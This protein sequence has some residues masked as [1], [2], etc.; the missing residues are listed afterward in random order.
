MHQAGEVTRRYPIAAILLAVYTAAVLLMTIGPVRQRLEGS[1]AP[2]GVL[3]LDRWV[4]ASTWETGATYEFV[5]NVLLF[6]PWGV[7]AV[8][9]LGE[10]RW[11]LA[12]VLGLG[13][14]LAIEIIQIPLARIS[15]PRDLA[16]NAMGALIGV[17]IGLAVRWAQLLVS[18][19]SVPLSAR[20]VAPAAQPPEG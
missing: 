9:A 10:R 11:W 13:L 6:V 20:R 14:T 1:E 7:L 5:F 17:A 3:S 2:L 8:L 12:A 18:P 19:A 4:E 15:D 16:A